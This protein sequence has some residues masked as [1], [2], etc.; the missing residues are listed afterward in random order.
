MDGSETICRRGNERFIYEL[1]CA[2]EALHALGEISG[3]NTRKSTTKYLH[4][5]A[6]IRLGRALC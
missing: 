5:C 6:S 1:T 3:P 2:K 4:D